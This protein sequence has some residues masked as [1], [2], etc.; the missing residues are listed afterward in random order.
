MEINIPATVYRDG[1]PPDL[2]EEQE[3]LKKDLY[4]KIAP[5]RRKFIDRIGYANWD[6]FP[7]PNDPMELRRDVTKRTTQE[8]IREFMQEMEDGKS[9][10][11]RHGALELALGIINR[12]DKFL[13][14]FD[15][16][17]WYYKLLA[18]EGHCDT[19]EQEDAE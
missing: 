19:P 9:N 10:S 7:K 14:C 11:Y 17:I 6:P 15:F 12:D 16:A 13:G 3:A 18:S 2:T 4:E 5:R 8:L 1:T